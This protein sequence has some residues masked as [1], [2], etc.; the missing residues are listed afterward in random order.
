MNFGKYKFDGNILSTV[1][2][3]SK[4]LQQST[5]SKLISLSLFLKFL[6]KVTHIFFEKILKSQAI[7]RVNF[8]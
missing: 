7:V 3:T 5:C 8:A 6:E 2:Y 1:I 4:L